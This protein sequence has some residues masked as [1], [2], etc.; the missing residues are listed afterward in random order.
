MDVDKCAVD[1]L[2]V[3]GFVSPT[4]SNNMEFSCAMV[5]GFLE[6]AKE[7]ILETWNGAKLPAI[8]R[9]SLKAI[10]STRNTKICRDERVLNGF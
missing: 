3:K 10:R 4:G 2:G 7:G 5:K 8:E 1:Y 6:R 9:L